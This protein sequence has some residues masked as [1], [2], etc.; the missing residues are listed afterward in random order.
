M[1]L[2][3]KSIECE[4][5]ETTF[6]TFLHVQVKFTTILAHCCK[7]KGGGMDE[8]LGHWT[9]NPELPASSLPL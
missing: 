7:Y 1:L 6:F 9:C 2:R 3:D 4:R 5:A 8:W